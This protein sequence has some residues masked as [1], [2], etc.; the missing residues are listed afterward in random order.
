MRVQNNLCYISLLANRNFSSFHKDYTVRKNQQRQT[1][2]FC[3]NYFGILM[4]R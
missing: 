1:V 3:L 2:S 4:F